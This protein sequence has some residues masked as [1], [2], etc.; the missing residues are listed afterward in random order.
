ME[1]SVVRQRVLESIERAK[2]TAVDR[3]A[4]TDEGAREYQYFLDRIAV[5][6][7]KQL[8]GVLRAENYLFNVFTPAGS[9]RLMSERGSD[10]YIEVT[11]DAKGSKAHIIGRSSRS[12][13]GNVTQS[14]RVLNATNTISELTE[15]DLLAFLL[16]ELEP[17]VEK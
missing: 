16:R 1:V 2:R 9:V 6:L 7:F 8:A 13:A 10:D 17:Y 14:E 5:P 15:D 12:K 4:Q 3:R 11:L